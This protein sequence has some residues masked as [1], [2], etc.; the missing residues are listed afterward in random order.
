MQPKVRLCRAAF[1]RFG[2]LD[3]YV[4]LRCLRWGGCRRRG[5]AEP[6]GPS[7]L[8]GPMGELAM[9]A[10]RASSV[11]LELRAQLGLVE[12]WS[13]L[14]L[15][16]VVGKVAIG[17]ILAACRA[18]GL[19]HMHH[20]AKPASTSESGSYL[21]PFWTAFPILAHA[22]AEQQLASLNRHG[23]RGDERLGAWGA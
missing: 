3:L 12:D 11:A 1:G 22:G 18:D 6:S 19:Q 5:L 10:P 16:V 17:S 23:V 9:L 15:E 21:L 20:A 13:S 7:E 2:L 14:K 8:L 4:T